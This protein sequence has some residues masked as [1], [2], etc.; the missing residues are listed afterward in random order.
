MFKRFLAVFSVSLLLM[1]CAASLVAA[2]EGITPEAAPPAMEQPASQPSMEKAPAEAPAPVPSAGKPESMPSAETAEAP[3]PAEAPT[4]A[5]S[6]GKMAVCT[7]IEERECVG[8]GTLFESGVG[9]LYCYSLVLGAEE[10]TVVHHVW[11]WNEEKMADVPLV[12]RSPRFRTYSSKNILP[13]WKGAW[14][15]E[16]VGPDGE[17]IS[18]AAFNVE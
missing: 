10:E 15:V 4:A 11:Y 17:I 2:Q 12:V 5:F 3:S 16:L 6:A 14:R 8:E 1:L 9:K 13:E 18:T 7:G